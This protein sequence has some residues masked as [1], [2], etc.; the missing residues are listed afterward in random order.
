MYNDRI[1]GAA[2]R[3]PTTDFAAPAIDVPTFRRTFSLVNV[4]T[5]TSTSAVG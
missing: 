5:G 4:S 3:S 1:T 2:N